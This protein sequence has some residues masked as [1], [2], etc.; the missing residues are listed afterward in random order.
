LPHWQAVRAVLLILGLLAAGAV[1]VP[2]SAADSPARARAEA[3]IIAGSL[4]D[5]GTLI[6]NGDAE[7]SDDEITV[8]DEGVVVGAAEA[9]A[10]ASRAGGQG[11]ARAA[12]LARRI[13]L[14]DGL[15]TATLARRTATATADGVV[16]AGR[17]VNLKV[18]GRQIGDIRTPSRYVLSDGGSVVVNKGRMAIRVTLGAAHGE[19][20]AGTRVD[21]AVAQAGAADAVVATPT[22]TPSATATPTPTPTPRPKAKRRKAP[23]VRER[24]T[25]QRYAFPVYGDASVADDFGAPRADTGAHEGNDVFA[26]FG[27]PVLAVADGVV[28]RVGTLPISGNRLWLRTAAGD[29]FFYAHLSAF[30]PDAVNG[31]KVKAGTVLGFTGNT[32]DAEPTP[33]H[34]HFE[35]HPGGKDA[36]DPH[37]ILLAWQE[38]RDVPP[39]AWLARHG[40]DTAE[41]PGALVEVRDFIAGE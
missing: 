19:S 39:G 27:A 2:V 40:A 32:G 13:D 20:P 25:G 38:N 9:V 18:E 35:I 34:V 23:K 3:S 30:S 1:L 10:R 4:G 24:L 15:V 8:E 21:V 28:E 17:I 6:A 33:P 14:F 37:A 26:E 31:R 29:A 11:S 5:F 16:Y 36:I 7:H 22:P 12:A 41:R